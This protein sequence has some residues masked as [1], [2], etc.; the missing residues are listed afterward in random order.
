[1]MHQSESENNKKKNQS[2]SY[3][4]QEL[5]KWIEGAEAEINDE[6]SDDNSIPRVL[7]WIE[8]NDNEI[9]NENNRIYL[10]KNKLNNIRES[11]NRLTDPASR[12]RIFDE[13]PDLLPKLII[14]GFALYL[15]DKIKPT[16]ADHLDYT[17]QKYHLEG[18][19]EWLSR[20]INTGISELLDS[21]LNIRQDIRDFLQWDKVLTPNEV[22]DVMI[23]YVSATIQAISE[24]KYF[25]TYIKQNSDELNY[26]TFKCINLIYQDVVKQKILPNELD[27]SIEQNKNKYEEVLF[28]KQSKLVVSNEST[29]RTTP[30]SNKHR[31]YQPEPASENVSNQNENANA[32]LEP[33]EANC[34]CSCLSFLNLNR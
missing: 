31:F 3:F 14:D 6:I 32:N 25:K 28:T 34:R 12:T 9:I 5:Q 8:L 19:R 26:Q 29:E 15:I 1:M 7:D 17:D 22:C 27:V 10:L 23:G 4:L 30:K 20:I 24:N 11:K 16:Q 33:N 21:S 18:I 2:G 13:F